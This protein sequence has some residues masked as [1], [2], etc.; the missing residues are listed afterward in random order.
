M[1][2]QDSLIAGRQSVGTHGCVT[3]ATCM[4]GCG[5]PYRIDVHA[6]EGI[7][8]SSASQQE[9]GRHQDV[10]HEAEEEECDVGG[11]APAR[12]CTGTAISISISLN[13]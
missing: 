4:A 3:S 7:H 12:I 11:L 2:V 1:P 8:D 13:F 10:G 6:G 5:A 9:H